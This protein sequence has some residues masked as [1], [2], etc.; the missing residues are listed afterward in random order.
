VLHRNEL[1]DA[2][3]RFPSDPVLATP[4]ALIDSKDSGF[5]QT[6]YT[7]DEEKTDQFSE[8][9]GLL[10]TKRNLR[11]GSFSAPDIGMTFKIFCDHLG[12]N[13]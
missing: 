4:S 13:C 6:E 7:I 2:A 3:D 1:M 9:S 5:E 8:V 10:I 12:Q 11:C